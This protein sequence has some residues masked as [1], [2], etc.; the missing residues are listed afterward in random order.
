MEVWARDPNRVRQGVIPA[1]KLTAVL[2]ETGVGT[3]TMTVDEDAEWSPPMGEGWGIIVYDQGQV[4][5]SGPAETIAVEDQGDGRDTTFTGKSDM[6]AL[7]RRLVLPSPGVSPEQQSAGY[8]TGKGP[9]EDLIA[10]L[11]NENAGPGAWTPWVTPGL[12]P[13]VSQGRGA[14]TSVNARFS[15]LLEEVQTLATVGNLVVDV[16]QEGEDLAV[17]VREP[18]NLSREIRFQPEAGLTSYSMSLAAPTVT[19]VL[20]AGQGVGAARTIKHYAGA[21]SWGGAI[22]VTFQD[23]RDTDDADE[24]VKAGTETL[25]EGAAS[26]SATFEAEE[27]EDQMFG[28]DFR[29]GDTVTVDLPH[30]AQVTDR[31]RVV[32]ITWDEFGRTVRPTVGA[33]STDEDKAPAWVKQIRDLKRQVR[34]LKESQ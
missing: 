12:L 25:A 29:L 34:H 4:V 2:R 11:I 7:Q 32:E 15:V 6:V 16:V 18:V 19:D 27:T 33:H 22:I 14:R 1:L 17:S 23:R 24:L 30:G 5:F 28:R 20:V 13:V 10:A 31:V 8:R 26:A 9:A 3:W 21:P